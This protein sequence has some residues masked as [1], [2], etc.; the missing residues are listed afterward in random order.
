MILVECFG[1]IL[2]ALDKAIETAIKESF[3]NLTFLEE[4]VGVK[5]KRP[6]DVS[7]DKIDN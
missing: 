7:Q 3:W 1:P 5:E 2:F 4:G 6:R